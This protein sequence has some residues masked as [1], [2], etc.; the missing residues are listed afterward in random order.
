[1]PREFSCMRCGPWRKDN[2]YNTLYYYYLGYQK[3]ILKQNKRDKEA[4]ILR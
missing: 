3:D 2:I 4:E 1:M